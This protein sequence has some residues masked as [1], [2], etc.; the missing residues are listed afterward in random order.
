MNVQTKGEGHLLAMKLMPAENGFSVQTEDSG[1]LL[2][3]L[4]GT[5]AFQHSSCTMTVSRGSAFETPDY[6]NFTNCSLEDLL[7]LLSGIGSLIGINLS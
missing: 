2:H 4:T 1:A 7:T 3:L 5:H 6:K